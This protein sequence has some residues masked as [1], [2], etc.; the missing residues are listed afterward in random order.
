MTIGVW[1]GTHTNT[2]SCNLEH[3]ELSAFRV[4][5]AIT[6]GHSAT[7]SP[8]PPITGCDHVFSHQFSGTGKRVMQTENVY[9]FAPV[10]C[11]VVQFNPPPSHIDRFGPTPIALS[12]GLVST[13]IDLALFVTILYLLKQFIVARPS[14]PYPPGPRGLPFVRNLFDWPSSN[15]CDTFTEWAHKYGM[16]KL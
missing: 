2:D 6:S 1:I 14:L 15:E 9:S 3:S 11:S 12:M 16:Y 10:F 7:G 5:T 4:E 13:F 8:K